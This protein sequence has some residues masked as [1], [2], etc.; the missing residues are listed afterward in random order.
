MRSVGCL[1]LHNVECVVNEVLT[2]NEHD[3]IVLSNVDA[4]WN[5]SELRLALEANQTTHEL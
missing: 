4:L 3:T 2:Q 5:A 1:S